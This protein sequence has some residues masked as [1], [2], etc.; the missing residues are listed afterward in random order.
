[1]SQ[2]P[3]EMLERIKKR[4][5]AAVAAQ[6]PKANGRKV[7]VVGAVVQPGVMSIAATVF[8]EFKAGHTAYFDRKGPG[9]GRFRS[10]GWLQAY[11]EEKAEIEERQEERREG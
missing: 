9:R 6:W 1:M 11:R 3:P 2:M 4:T 10:A 8:S 7:M 5:L